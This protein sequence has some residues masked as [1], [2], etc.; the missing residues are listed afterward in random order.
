MHSYINASFLPANLHLL[1]T[2]QCT[3]KIENVIVKGKLVKSTGGGEWFLNA[4]A[5]S[6]YSRYKET[7]HTVLP[8]AT[9][10]LQNLMWYNICLQPVLSASSSRLRE[11]LYFRK[12]KSCTHV[13]I[14][15]PYNF[16]LKSLTKL[17][18]VRGLKIVSLGRILFHVHTKMSFPFYPSDLIFRYKLE[19]KAFTQLITCFLF[20]FTWFYSDITNHIRKRETT[21]TTLNHKKWFHHGKVNVNISTRRIYYS[22]WYSLYQ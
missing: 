6:G 17:V 22:F 8:E 3:P 5:N 4:L 21:S 14:F 7:T 1:S 2:S 20:Q 10:C 11:I 13:A 15:F 19:E 16:C 9:K 18:T 12:I